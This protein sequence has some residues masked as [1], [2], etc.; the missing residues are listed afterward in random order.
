[1][2]RPRSKLPKYSYHVSGQATVWLHYKRYFL[3]EYDSPESRARYLELVQ[4]YNDNGQTMPGDVA[5]R[6]KETPITV[7][8]VLAKWR[9]YVAEQPQLSR[10]DS[11]VSVLQIEYGAIAAH[12]FGPKR[13]KEFRELL[14]ADRITRQN[15]NE[16]VRAVCRIF[17]HAASEELVEYQ[18]YDRLTTV[19]P[20]RFGRT[21][22]PE[23][24]RRQ[25]ANL[26]HVAATVRELTPIVAD[27][28]RVQLATGMR[29]SEVCR[30]RPCD[31]D[32]SGP[33]WI[34]RPDQHKTAHRQIRKAVPIV[35][36]ARR[37]I[38]NYIDRDPQ[39]YC[40]SPAEAEAWRLAKR[41][42]DRK[43]PLN[44]GN[45]PGKSSGPKASVQQR[46]GACYT[47]DSYRRAIQRAAKRAGVPKWLPSQLRHNTATEVRNAIGLEAAQALLGH[48]NAAMTEHYARE[49][50]QTAIEAAKVAPRLPREI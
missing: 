17:K 28:V 27:M 26:H 37:A 10:Y 49:S 39:S 9:E 30:I 29:P 46:R 11:M 18:V 38:E 48:T 32:R 6:Q 3:G 19:E 31:I 47:K 13:L 5:T 34:Y 1:M 44:Q 23:Q 36:E 22:A 7:N 15:I 25:P 50:E 16:Q 12:E 24:R 35:A 14:I 8:Q 2:G 33:E 42:A 21:Q 41:H 45:R 4:I 40:F 43:T 20:L